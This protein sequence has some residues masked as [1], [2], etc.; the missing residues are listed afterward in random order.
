M[1]RMGK[2]SSRPTIIHR[3]S[4]SLDRSENPEKFPVGPMADRPGPTLLSQVSAAEKDTSKGVLSNDTTRAA[5]SR[6]RL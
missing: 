6:I 1:T 2:I 4:T 3:D 5:P